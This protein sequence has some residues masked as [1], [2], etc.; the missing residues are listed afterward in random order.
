M[1][2]MYAEVTD[3]T[4]I[5]AEIATAAADMTAA[6]R[7]LAEL[8]R[9]DGD[10]PNMVAALSALIAANGPLDTLAADLLGDGSGWLDDF[11]DETAE[12]ASNL[13]GDAMSRTG[14]LNY[15]LEIIRDTLKP[16][17]D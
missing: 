14:Q 7:R 16:L 2:T 6:I 5:N 3:D 4:D 9:M 17:A 8:S 11:E 13:M 12:F 10:V 1:A 15:E